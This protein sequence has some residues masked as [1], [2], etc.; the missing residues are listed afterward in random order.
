MGPSITTTETTSEILVSNRLP[1][2]SLANN[3]F[4]SNLNRCIAAS[5]AASAAATK[6]KINSISITT[7]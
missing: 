4:V 5:A 7:Q 2:I 3:D 6:T 1:L